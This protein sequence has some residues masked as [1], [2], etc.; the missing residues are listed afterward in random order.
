MI[1][2][3]VLSLWKQFFL[4]LVISAIFFLL[5]PQV[6][7]VITYN[8]SNEQG[9]GS[10]SGKI[11]PP[12]SNT[13]VYLLLPGPFSNQSIVGS[14]KINDNGEYAFLE[15]SRGI[16]NIIVIAREGYINESR[17]L[18]GVE[19]NKVTEIPD[20]NLPRIGKTG[21]ISG[22][23]NPVIDGTAVQIK[24]FGETTPVSYDIVEEDGL[25]EISGLEPGTYSLFV[26]F[27][28]SQ[29]FYDYQWGMIE[30][31]TNV[32]LS[33]VNLTFTPRDSKYLIDRIM[34]TFV[35]GVS[36]EEKTDIIKS[37]GCSLM[38]HYSYST[39]YVI[40]IPQDKTVDE[41]VS[42][43]RSGTR[44]LSA[45]P[46]GIS[47]TGGT[48]EETS[49]YQLSNMTDIDEAIEFISKNENIE[50]SVGA[51]N[52]SIIEDSGIQTSVR[53]KSWFSKLFAFFRSLF[54]KEQEI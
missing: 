17:M 34:I 5:L 27:D 42:I 18:I 32:S 21:S 40:N 30:I 44:I 15:I 37:Y 54:R 25:Y 6:H 31:I 11:L 14:E 43:F 2:K 51:D 28:K 10:I 20:I 49:S 7:G 24:K 1:R 9:T 53:E 26:G 48:T 22:Y 41:E 39:L 33:G 8:T 19:E 36:D 13:T 38:S 45:Y 52:Q 46:V 47:Y 12:D 3:S 50:V 29:N 23:I 35:D 16:Y 4:L